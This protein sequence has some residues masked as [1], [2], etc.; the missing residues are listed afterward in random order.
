MFLYIL[1]KNEDFQIIIIPKTLLIL[2][3]IRMYLSMN[4]NISKCVMN[5]FVPLL[6]IF[7][8]LEIYGSPQQPMYYYP[9]KI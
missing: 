3:H 4:T 2:N 9:F 8:T 1:G 5:I 7:N 6:E